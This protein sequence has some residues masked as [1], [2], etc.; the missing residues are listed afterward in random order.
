M[1]TDLVALKKWARMAG[2]LTLVLAI[3]G[4]IALMAIPSRFLVPG[5]AAATVSHLRAHENLFRV[6]LVIDAVICFVEIVL[7]VV[8][9]ELFKPVNQTLSLVAMVFRLAMAVLQGVNLVNKLFVLLLLG[10]AG[11]VSAWG[12]ERLDS[13]VMLFL[14]GN[15]K[16]VFVWQAFFGLHCF[17]LGY[18]AFRSG[19]IPRVVGL[20]LVLAA[21]GYFSDSLGNFL[22]ADYKSHYGWIVTVTAPVG[23]LVFMLWLLIKG[24]A[25]PKISG[26]AVQ[27]A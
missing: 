27:A 4:P 8:L 20:L 15:A 7:P 5:D 11:F 2:W 1:T 23:E 16:V 22:A 10:S 6:G 13:L 19:Y 12:P 26:A 17:L 9:F 21:A 18:L 3:L 25:I 24:V 14:E